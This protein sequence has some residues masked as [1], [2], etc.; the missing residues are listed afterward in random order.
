MIRELT[1]VGEDLELKPAD[2]SSGFKRTE[3][4]GQIGVA[5]PR[6]N[7][8]EV[9]PWRVAPVAHLDAWQDSGTV[10][11]DIRQEVV[12]I[13]EVVDIEQDADVRLSNLVDQSDRAHPVAAITGC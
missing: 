5:I 9:V 12:G 2:D 4:A 6:K 1:V 8:I 7:A 11:G 10:R 3:D 13:P